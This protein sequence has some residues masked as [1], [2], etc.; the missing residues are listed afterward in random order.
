MNSAHCQSEYEVRF[1]WGLAGALAVAGEV[2]VAVVVDVLSFT[3]TLSVAVDL[4]TVVLPYRWNDES[5]RDFARQHDAVLA[6]GRS[7]AGFGQVSLSPAS[8]RSCPVPPARLVLPSPNGST[9]AHHLAAS[10]VVCLG[11]CLRNATAVASWIG[12]RR[13]RGAKTV[14]VIAAGERWPGGELRPAAEDAWGAG[15]VIAQLAAHG[16]SG[17]SPEPSSLVQRMNLSKAGSGSC[18]W[19]APAGESWS[20]RATAPMWK[21]PQK[22]A[23]ATAFRYL[24]TS[25]SSA[26]ARPE[27]VPAKDPPSGR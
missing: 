18:S 16:W 24:K 17:L 27:G 19:T 9:I 5:A 21:S 10:S 13:P 12:D 4:G 2:D 25:A 22:S 8:W 26:P 6:V 23:L 3:T 20:S 14:A 15:A 11:A 1:D 7:R